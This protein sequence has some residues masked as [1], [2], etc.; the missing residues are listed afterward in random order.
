MQSYWRRF[1]NIGKE[2]LSSI[3]KFSLRGGQFESCVIAGLTHISDVVYH[4]SCEL[5]R[6]G[7][8]PMIIAAILGMLSTASLQL[9]L[10]QYGNLENL[11]PMK[12]N[13]FCFLKFN[14]A[15]YYFLNSIFIIFAYVAPCVRICS[16]EYSPIDILTANLLHHRR[17]SECEDQ[18]TDGVHRRR[19]LI[20]KFHHIYS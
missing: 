3:E 4:H 9:V 1:S 19:R 17:R 18:F 5:D 16:N 10:R 15:T 8:F 12:I 7:W 2:S 13:S 6:F 14:S 20:V 11:S